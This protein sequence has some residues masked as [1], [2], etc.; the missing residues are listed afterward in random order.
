MP[1]RL[2]S[3]PHPKKQ[4]GLALLAALMLI[5][6]AALFGINMAEN[7]RNHQDIAAANVRYATVQQAGELT[8]KRTKRFLQQLKNKLPITNNALSGR[9]FASNFDQ[10]NLITAQASTGNI[11]P[12]FIWQR[13]ALEDKICGIN[14]CRSGIYFDDYLENNEHIW[15]DYAIISHFDEG[16]DS[17]NYLANTYTY[18]FIQ[19]LNPIEP[20]PITPTTPGGTIKPQYYLITVLAVGYPPE[21]PTTIE[22]A[23][24][25]YL[26]QAFFIKK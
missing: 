13:G 6:L 20:N 11:I 19:S 23:R 24:E 7:S 25:R 22:N 4:Q 14:Q 21:T 5:A 12:A 1:N 9:D 15:Q 2:S 17:Q 10:A 18:T 3:L 26:T 16:I 8:L